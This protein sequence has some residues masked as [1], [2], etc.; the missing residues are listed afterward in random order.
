MKSPGPM[1]ERRR[2]GPSRWALVITF[3]VGA[4]FP[5]TAQQSLK[6]SPAPSRSFSAITD[7]G[8]EIIQ[9]PQ[10]AVLPYDGLD[11][12]MWYYVPFNLPTNGASLVLV[13]HGG[14]GNGLVTMG[15]DYEERWNRIADQEK[16]VVLY[17]EGR[18]D[19]GAT[20]MYHWNDCRAD[21]TIPQADSTEDDVGYFEML[22][23]WAQSTYSVNTNKVYIAGHSNGGLM[24]LRA[25]AETGHRYAAAAC[26]IGNR[27]ATNECAAATVPV[28][29]LIMNG[30]DDPLIPNEG[31]CA[32]SCGSGRGMVTSTA[33]T[34]SYW[35]NVNQTVGAPVV[36]NLPDI[37]T[38]DSSTVTVT[39]YA[40]GIDNAEVVY[41]RI[42]GGGHTVPGFDPDPFYQGFVGNRNKDI[43]AADEIWDFFKN[44]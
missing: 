28:P 12:T 1:L 18:L 23:D 27:A 44:Y 17:P 13:L 31:G 2:S 19:P 16:F 40:Q 39:T 33:D 5:A 9:I 36:T 37:N 34:I 11:R 43:R 7:A 8:E 25:A 21:I 41:Y 6:P 42:N 38:N 15:S 10:Y 3:I 35:T 14:G 30:T 4:Y 29:M 26:V 24:V 22:I 32:T 20:L